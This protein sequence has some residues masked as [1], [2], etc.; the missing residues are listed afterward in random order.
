MYVNH[1]GL[2]KKFIDNPNLS[3]SKIAAKIM[4][5]DYGVTDEDMINAVSYH[6]TGRANMSRLEKIIFL[7]DAIEPRRNYPSVERLRE[8]AYEDLDE[9]CIYSLQHT[10]EYVR[11]KGNYLDE[12]TVRALEFLKGERTYD[13]TKGFS[14]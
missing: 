3:H 4:E 7:A 13:G 8:L 6:T 1:F 2:P 11:G 14:D 10:V 5:R 9:A 12:D